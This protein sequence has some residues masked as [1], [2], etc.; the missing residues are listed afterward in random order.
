MALALFAGARPLPGF[1]LPLL[2]ALFF[3]PAHDLARQGGPLLPLLQRDLRRGPHP[4]QRRRGLPLG[5]AGFERFP[6]LEGEKLALMGKGAVM[7]RFMRH[8]LA[9]HTDTRRMEALS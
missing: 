7:A 3:A 8:N 2:P 5:V 1:S 6:V 4:F 9:V